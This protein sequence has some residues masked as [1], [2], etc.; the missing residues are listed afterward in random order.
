MLN[1]RRHR[2][3]VW[4]TATDLPLSIRRPHKDQSSETSSKLQRRRFMAG[5]EQSPQTC[6]STCVSCGCDLFIYLIYYYYYLLL[7]IYY[8]FNCFATT[9]GSGRIGDA[10]VYNTDCLTGMFCN[11]GICSCLSN[12]VQYD[13]YCYES[14]SSTSKALGIS[15]LHAQYHHCLEIN[16]S[17]AGCIY[18]EQCNAVWPGSSLASSRVHLVKMQ[19]FVKKKHQ[20]K[21]INFRSYVQQNGWQR[22]GYL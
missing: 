4:P 5:I 3:S 17:L 9:A 2:E 16:P 21:K 6:L 13:K 12:Y 18:P 7:L 19:K 11:G 1:G 8:L 20:L 22:A 15:K 10:C 14:T